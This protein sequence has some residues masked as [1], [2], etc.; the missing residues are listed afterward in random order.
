MEQSSEQVAN[1]EIEEDKETSF[2]CYPEIENHYNKDVL[3]LVENYQT[4]E[5]WVATEKIH[6]TNFAFVCDGVEVICAKRTSLL[7]DKDS[8][9]NF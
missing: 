3:K 2:K 9:Y 1:N 6:G 5:I 7:K 8:F 4:D